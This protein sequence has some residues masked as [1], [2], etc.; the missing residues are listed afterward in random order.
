VDAT[1]GIDV[2]TT[3]VK[4]AVVDL[5]GR[6]LVEGDAGYPTHHLG[7]GRV[8]QDADDW[9]RASV[10]AVNAALAMAPR[11]VNVRAIGVSGQ[12]CALTP[13][14]AAGQPLR[15]AI[16]WLDTRAEAQCAWMRDRASDTVYAANGNAIAPY[17]MDPK[18]AWLLEHEPAV[19]EAATSFLTTTA[20]VTRRLAGVN[21]MNRSDG[22]ILFSYDLHTHDWSD[23][24]LRAIGLPRAKLPRVAPC[25]SVVGSLTAEAA[26]AL[27]LAAGVPVIAGGEDTSAAAL[28]AGVVAPGQAY[29]SLGTA[30]VVGVCLAEALPQP[31][32]L[33]FPHVLD[34]LLLLSGSMSSFGAAVQWFLDQFGSR[35]VAN[36]FDA[37][38]AEAAESPP[39]ARNLVFLPYLSG[40]LH[41]ILDPLARGTFIGLSMATTRNDVVRAI[42]EGGA[43]AVRN[44]LD[45]AREA[46]AEP[47]ELRAVGGPTR[48]ATWCQAIADVTGLPLRVLSETGGA[49]VGMALLAAAGTGLISDLPRMAKE[50]TG[51]GSLFSPEMR[52]GDV[53]DSLYAVYVS[54]YRALKPQFAA[55]AAVPAQPL[56]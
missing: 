10:T 52:L 48:S 30:G 37:L 25:T 53:Y 17:N 44:N 51:S 40:E 31:R 7:A 21:V 9:W 50:R 45:A 13:V 4:A 36:G 15:R 29:L 24:V 2:G 23:P 11:R 20:F 16:I 41:P 14:D 18:A 38:S 5:A 49:S 33:S 6:V 26:Q 32:L 1:L 8:E 19:F 55:L 28:A 46:G 47:T 34:G 56:A 43:F 3:N 27:G 12:G 22:G 54:T 39:G 35:G 42:M